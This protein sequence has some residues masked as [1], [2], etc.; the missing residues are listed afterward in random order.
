MMIPADRIAL[1][2]DMDN[3]V[4]SSRIDFAAIR[5][6]LIALLRAAGGAG[7]A[8][9][10]LLRRAIADLVARGAAHDRAHG[11]EM[12]PRMWK[13]IEAH[14]AEGLK[15]AGALDD[16]P[17]VLRRLKDRRH[18]IA[19]L[20]NNGREA[21]L[22]ALRS[23]GVSDYVEIIVARGDAPALKPAGD[24]VAEAVRRLGN[25]ERTYVIGD[26]WIDGAAAAAVGA[27][28]IAYRRTAEDLQPHGI[29]PW[30]VIGNLDELLHLDLA[31]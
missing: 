29:R 7:E 8:E 21:A 28:F 10:M 22:Q 20:T 25:V 15:D 27:R 9:E 2:F 6:G 24:G 3:T 23:A 30:R 26:S 18:R 19:I 4:I 17:A 1:V 13:I 12:V 31:G 11:T 16:A 5:R 14:E